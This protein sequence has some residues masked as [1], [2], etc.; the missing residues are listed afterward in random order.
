MFT[1]IYLGC[2]S[3]SLSQHISSNAGL[4]LASE[5]VGKFLRYL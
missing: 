1:A 4:L 3:L 5:E 2:Y